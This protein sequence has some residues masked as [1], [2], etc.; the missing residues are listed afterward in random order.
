VKRKI[1]MLEEGLDEI[2]F[3]KGIEI[4]STVIDEMAYTMRHPVGL[5]S[6]DLTGRSDDAGVRVI[7]LTGEILVMDIVGR[8]NLTSTHLTKY[9][10]GRRR[11]DRRR[12]KRGEVRSGRIKIGRRNQRGVHKC[13]KK[14]S[15]C[16]DS[17]ALIVLMSRIQRIDVVE[18]L[19]ESERTSEVCI[20]T[21]GIKK[22]E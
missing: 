8:I 1:G 9:I 20:G 12:I 13:I 18:K 16:L 21:K 10:V 5:V 4:G 7:G 14:S 2:R 6:N 3:R 15:L 19:V 22:A 17:R 11:N